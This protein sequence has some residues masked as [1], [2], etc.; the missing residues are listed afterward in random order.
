MPKHVVD[1]WAQVMKESA[2][3]PEFIAN[4]RKIGAVP[5]HNDPEATR[6]YVKEEI[7]RAAKLFGAPK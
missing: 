2:A 7:E 1:F 6:A 4:A 3:D 5:F